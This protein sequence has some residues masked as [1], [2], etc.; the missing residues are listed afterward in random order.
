MV[1]L[2]FCLIVFSIY[3]CEASQDS[4]WSD[5]PLFKS[6]TTFHPNSGATPDVASPILEKLQVQTLA[7]ESP[8][9]SSPT[10]KQQEKIHLM[11]P[12]KRES[13]PYK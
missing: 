10:I 12:K 8:V 3:A 13:V 7:V 2:L 4:P 11:F 9:V 1:K 6:D 5:P